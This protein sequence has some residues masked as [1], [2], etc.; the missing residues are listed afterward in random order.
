MELLP[1]ILVT[2]LLLG[3]FI[4]IIFPI[5]PGVP[6][7]F[8]VML[9]YGIV[10][11][12]AQVSGGFLIFFGVLALI[13]III[14]YTSG[15]LGGKLGGATKKAALWG[16]IG[17]IIGTLFAPLIGTFLGLF[18]G[19]VAA[20]I[21]QLRTMQQV[22]KAGVGGVLGGIVGLILNLIIALTFFIV[23][24]IAIF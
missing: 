4:G 2:I 13:S 22:M 11:D 18:F 9:G 15:V 20:E 1:E 3:G 16:F 12:F 14:D 6:Y 8:L 5:F 10:T 17:S 7:M 24:V 23:G 19:I 21:S